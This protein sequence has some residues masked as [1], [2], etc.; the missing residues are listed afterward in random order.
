MKLVKTTKHHFIY[1]LSEKEQSKIENGYKYLLFNK[2]NYED[3]KPSFQYDIGY[4][5]WQTDT[6]NEALDFS[7]N[8]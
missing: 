4:E 5:D 7:I 3:Y 2:A 1:E 8:Y 6:L